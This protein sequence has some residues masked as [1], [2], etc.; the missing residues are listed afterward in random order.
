MHKVLDRHHGRLHRKWRPRRYGQLQYILGELARL[1]FRPG[2]RLAQSRLE[3][4]MAY[5][6]H[7]N[8]RLVERRPCLHLQRGGVLHHRLHLDRLA[9]DVAFARHARLDGDVA[10]AD[11][12]DAQILLRAATHREL[13]VFFPRGRARNNK[14]QR[15]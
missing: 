11:A 7:E 15:N 5:A 1:N 14:L 2:D 12:E 9:G 3:R 13:V 8:L 4:T 10:A 6:R